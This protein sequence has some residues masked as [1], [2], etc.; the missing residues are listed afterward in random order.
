MQF[1]HYLFCYFFKDHG[2]TKKAVK[3]KSNFFFIFFVEFFL[4]NTGG[5]SVKRFDMLGGKPISKFLETDSLADTLFF[6]KKLFFPPMKSKFIF[7]VNK[8]FTIFQKNIF[9]FLFFFLDKYYILHYKIDSLRFNTVLGLNKVSYFH[10]FFLELEIWRIIVIIEEV[11][12]W[13]IEKSE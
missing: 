6:V 8:I 13:Y 7:F 3:K 4:K 12:V 5:E 1:W 9:V 10:F 11:V 2:T